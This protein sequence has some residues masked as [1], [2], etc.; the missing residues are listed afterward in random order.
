MSNQAIHSYSNREA[1]DTRSPIKKFDEDG[2][3]VA[4]AQGLIACMAVAL[5]I[6]GAMT[7]TGYLSH[8]TLGG[9]AIGLGAGAGIVSL[10]WVK[11]AD[12]L[13]ERIVALIQTIALVTV[14]IFG[15]LAI[16]GTLPLATCGWVVFGPT[17]SIIVAGTAGAIVASCAG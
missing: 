17:L 7:A 6:I 14:L 13:V 8:V 9:S 4:V 1:L 15:A 12:H 10:L 5:C 3:C 11:E 2:I 16:A